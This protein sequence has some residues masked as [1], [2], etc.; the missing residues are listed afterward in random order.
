MNHSNNI[1]TVA[2][3]QQLSTST[4]SLSESN[5]HQCRDNVS[6]HVLFLLLFL[7]PPLF[8]VPALI[9]GR[10]K[11]FSFTSLHMLDCPILVGMQS[12]FLVRMNCLLLGGPDVHNNRQHSRLLLFL[13]VGESLFN[14]KYVL[15]LLV[16]CKPFVYLEN[17]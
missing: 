13:L 12:D 1:K 5:K 16:W 9:G 15:Q 4:E 11:V 7:L 17:G 6:T 2:V 10:T 8:V 3:Y 14:K